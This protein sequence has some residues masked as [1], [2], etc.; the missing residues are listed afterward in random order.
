MKLKM[1]D[2]SS[3]NLYGKI[4]STWATFKAFNTFESQYK[5]L[6]NDVLGNIE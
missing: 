5:S 6:I 2:L 1:L 4:L 3:N